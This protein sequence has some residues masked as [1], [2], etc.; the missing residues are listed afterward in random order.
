MTTHSFALLSLLL[1][2]VGV[3]LSSVMASTN[4]L[5]LVVLSDS[6]NRHRHVTVP[7]GDVLSMRFSH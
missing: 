2:L 3:I 5:T 1:L 7:P 4:A 6:H